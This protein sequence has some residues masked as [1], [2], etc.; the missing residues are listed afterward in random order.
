MTEFATYPSLR[1]RTVL[2]TGGASGIGAS[3]VEHFV[4]QGAR[5]GFIDLDRDAASKLIEGLGDKAA[6]C[7]FAIADLRDI[8]ALKRAITELRAELGGPIT[9]LV[10]NAARDDRHKIDDVTPEYWDERMATNLRHQFF[11]VQA[12]KDE[13]IAAGGGSIINMSS[14][15]FL[16]GQGGMPA[17]LTAKSA[18]IGLTRGLARDLGPHH[19]RVNTVVPGWIMTERQ[20]ALWLN[21]E[22]EAEVLKGQCIPEKL[23]PPD[24]ARMVLWLAADDSRL[25]AAQSFVIDGGWT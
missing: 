5:V 3:I 1:G 2:I 7:R 24:I 14:V 15:S 16:L 12:V 17:Y 20:I 10:N 23:Y 6:L 13:M 18:V 11:A 9:V 19:I 8:D 21:P 25:V 22:A 4:A